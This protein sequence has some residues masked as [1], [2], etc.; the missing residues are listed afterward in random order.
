MYQQRYW[1]DANFEAV[2]RL[3]SIAATAHRSLISVSLNWLLHHTPAASIILGASRLEQLDQN[4]A[5]CGEGALDSA[6]VEAC[7]EVWPICAV[8]SHLQPLARRR[9]GN[10]KTAGDR[11]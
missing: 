1:H 8:R 6:T 3:Q 5:A 11:G 9:I 7:D 10:A 2:E 4:L